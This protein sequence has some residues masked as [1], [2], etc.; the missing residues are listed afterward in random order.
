MASK[1]L[2][3]LKKVNMLNSKVT[4][5]KQNHLFIIYADFQNVLVPENN[6]K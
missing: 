3:C 5:D 6:G 1:E 4:K 2:S